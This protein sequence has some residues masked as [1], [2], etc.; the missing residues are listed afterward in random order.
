LGFVAFFVV[1]VALAGWV[2]DQRAWSVSA[3][4]SLD[5]YITNYNSWQLL[6]LLEFLCNADSVRQSSP[7]NEVLP[8]V[9]FITAR[10]G[11][12][13]AVFKDYIARM[14]SLNRARRAGSIAVEVQP[15]QSDSRPPQDAL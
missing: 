11:Q 14:N 3:L 7:K 10:K 4:G 1:M 9:K 6:R 8:A 15:L 5:K 13:R 12:V 2:P